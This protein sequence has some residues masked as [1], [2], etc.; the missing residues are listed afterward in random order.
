MRAVTSFVSRMRSRIHSAEPPEQL[1]AEAI[2][3][4]ALGDADVVTGD[5]TGAQKF[6]MHIPVLGEV[7]IRLGW[8]EATVDRVIAEAERVAFERGWNPPLAA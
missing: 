7:R 5:I 4:S 2:I 8:D 1:A 6:S 3:R